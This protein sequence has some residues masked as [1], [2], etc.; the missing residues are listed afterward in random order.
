MPLATYE[1]IADWYDQSI[2]RGTLLPRE[3][4]V[5]AAGQVGAY[6]RTLGTSL[7]AFW[8]AGLLLE[9]AVEPQLEGREEPPVLVVR[10][11][12]V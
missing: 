5:A 1:A 7:S 10:C 2:R 9:S 6:H 12:R 8:Q 3:Q 4:L 11:R